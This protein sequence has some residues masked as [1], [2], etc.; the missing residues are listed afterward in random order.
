MPVEKKCVVCGKVF[1]VPPARR[2]TAKACSHECAVIVRAKSRERK[3][4]KVC[5][6]CGKTFD[7][8]RSHEGRRVHCSRACHSTDPSGLA[9]RSERS[10]G[11]KNPRWIGGRT[12]H[13]DG[14]VYVLDKSHPF[15]TPNGYIFEHRVVVEGMA[16]EEGTCPFM[17]LL[18][19]KM[20]LSPDVSVHHLD[21]DRSNNSPDNLVA[22]SPSTHTGLHNGR[23]LEEDEYWPVT[24]SSRSVLS[25]QETIEV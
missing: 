4:Q 17:V 25:N 22:C 2:D 19:D 13:S 1:S 9:E 18:G 20:Y 7:C 8:P 11:D 3:V 5:P 10:L 23:F 24:E 6:T 14:Y 15:S 21:R 16:R 12:M